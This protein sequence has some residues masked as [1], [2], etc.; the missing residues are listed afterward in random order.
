MKKPKKI[1]SPEDFGG[2]YEGGIAWMRARFEKAEDMLRFSDA[3]EAEAKASRSSLC[4]RWRDTR[5]PKMADPATWKPNI[6]WR[7]E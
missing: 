1:A 2:V 5:C 6:C 4:I 3:L 7:W